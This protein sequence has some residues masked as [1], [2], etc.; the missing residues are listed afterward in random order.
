[1][2]NVIEAASARQKQAKKRS[3]PGVN[4]H[5]EPVLNEAMATHD[6]MDAGVRATQDAKAEIVFQ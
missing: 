1:M 5:F 2:K 3:L 4:E 6:C